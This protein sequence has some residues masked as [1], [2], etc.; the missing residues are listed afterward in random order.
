MPRLDPGSPEYEADIN[1]S[2]IN[3]SPAQT[4]KYLGSC[5]LFER[6]VYATPCS[7]FP[8]ARRSLSVLSFREAKKFLFSYRLDFHFY[9]TILE[10][11]TFPRV[12]QFVV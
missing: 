11:E 8:V 6:C 3:K 4:V 2:F 7:V 12:V 9:V 10:S 1:A 5:L